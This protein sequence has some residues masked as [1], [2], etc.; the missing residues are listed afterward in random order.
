[1]GRKKLDKFGITLRISPEIESRLDWLCEVSGLSRSALFCDLV[2]S[3]YDKLHNNEELKGMIEGLQD[4]NKIL[5]GM[6]FNV[7][8]LKKR[9]YTRRNKDD[10]YYADSSEVISDDDSQ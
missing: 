6:D 10:A 8:L 2:N 9:K 7:N 3:Q 4:I 1:M 5:S